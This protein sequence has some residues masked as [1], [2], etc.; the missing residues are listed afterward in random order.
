MMARGTREG[1]DL[2]GVRWEEVSVWR[3][4]LWGRT[5]TGDAGLGGLGEGWA[6][7]A[8]LGWGSAVAG[9]E[10]RAVRGAEL[11]ST[12]EGAAGGAGLGLLEKEGCAEL[13]QGL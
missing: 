10:G 5:V 7:G 12:A 6:E 11:G 3:G 4:R 8:G 2:G 1:G 9:V 13:C